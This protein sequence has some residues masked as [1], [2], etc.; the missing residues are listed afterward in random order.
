MFLMS[1]K[2]N[3]DDREEQDVVARM[4][5]ALPKKV[6]PVLCPELSYQNLKIQN[7][8][9]A[10]IQWHRLMDGRMTVIE[11]EK[12]YQELLEYRCCLDT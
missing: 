9:A 1:R 7:G 2:V 11:A 12:T 3:L 8:G 5:I 6:L 10:V 4:L